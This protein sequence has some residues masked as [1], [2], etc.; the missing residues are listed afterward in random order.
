MTKPRTCQTG[1]SEKKNILLVSGV[2]CISFVLVAKGTRTAMGTFERC[3]QIPLPKA[4]CLAPIPE[5]TNDVGES[6]SAQRLR[7]LHHS[8]LD[9]PLRVNKLKGCFV[10]FYFFNLIS[11]AKSIPKAQPVTPQ[12]SAVEITEPEYSIILPFKTWAAKPKGR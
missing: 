4:R 1:N 3:F 8:C 12:T 5:P 9:A 2:F 11:P 10:F 6:Q 7:I